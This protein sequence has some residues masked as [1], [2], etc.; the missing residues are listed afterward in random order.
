[1]L[2]RSPDHR[3]RAG[4]TCE[5]RLRFPVPAA[6]RAAWLRRRQGR[7]PPARILRAARRH[8]SPNHLFV[9]SAKKRSNQPFLKMRV[10]AVLLLR[11][12]YIDRKST[13]LNSI[14]NAP[15]V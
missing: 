15:L 9:P 11:G 14:T 10:M 5:T 3:A 2:F 1:M 6:P 4:P 13:R 8:E 7:R 12:L